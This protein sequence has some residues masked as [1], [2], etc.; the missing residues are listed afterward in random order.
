[1][2]TLLYELGSQ[3]PVVQDEEQ[4]RPGP[5][6]PVRESAAE[7]D[8]PP[9]WN[10]RTV[11]AEPLVD[12]GPTG[13]AR[14]AGDWTPRERQ[15]TPDMRGITVPQVEINAVVDGHVSSVGYAAGKEAAGD[16][17][18]WTHP[19]ANSLEPVIRDGIDFGYTQFRSMPLAAQDGSGAFLSS[20]LE[21]Q[22]P[23]YTAGLLAAAQHNARV[24]RQASALGEYLTSQM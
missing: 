2:S 24:A 11:D 5:A 4:V 6:E 14:L 17:G 7:E 12:R 1:M 19:Y 22:D 23:D 20:P 10:E 15:S 8:G 9:E 3:V 16:A 13:A 18:Q 21:A